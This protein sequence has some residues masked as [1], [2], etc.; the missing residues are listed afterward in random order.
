VKD[1]GRLYVVRLTDVLLQP[2]T[3]SH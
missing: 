1:Y 3:I 2:F